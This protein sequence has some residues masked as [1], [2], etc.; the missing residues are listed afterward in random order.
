M[1]HLNTDRGKNL[2]T[3]SNIFMFL[4]VHVGKL[5]S[6]HSVPRHFPRFDVINGAVLPLVLSPK[7]R[8]LRE[9]FY[10]SCL[11]KN[12]KKYERPKDDPKMWASEIRVRITPEIT[13]DVEMAQEQES[14]TQPSLKLWMCLAHYTSFELHKIKMSHGTAT[15]KYLSPVT[16]YPRE[17][18]S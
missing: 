5:A 9:E 16:V 7:K 10:R 13:D 1:E 12:P 14:G 11:G 4:K 6:Y 17:L 18:F 8:I 3:V 2:K 15:N